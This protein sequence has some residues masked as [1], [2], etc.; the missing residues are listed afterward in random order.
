MGLE[1]IEKPLSEPD[2]GQFNLPPS[3]DRSALAAKWVQK[4]REVEQARV[5]QT[6]IGEP[7]VSADGWDVFKVDGKPYTTVTAKAEWVLMS[8]SREVQDS[9]NAVYGNVGTKRMLAEKQTGAVSKSE[10]RATGMLSDDALTQ[11]G[12]REHR[13]E[14]NDGPRLNPVKIT[15][16]VLTP[17]PIEL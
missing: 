14:Q 8:R 9:V 6:L 2:A 15:S 10:T 1:I 4:G 11:A 17:E 16:P 5:R 12:L 7:N 3:F 13:D